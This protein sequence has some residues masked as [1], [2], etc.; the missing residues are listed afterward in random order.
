MKSLYNNNNYNNDSFS[1][2]YGIKEIYIWH[3]LPNFHVTNNLSC[4][5]IHDMLGGIFRYNIA[6]IINCLIKKN[7]SLLM[8]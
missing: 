7:I 4:D 3:E 6:Q 1:L 5:L 2:A 8:N